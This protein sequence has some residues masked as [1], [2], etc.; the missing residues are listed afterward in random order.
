MSLAPLHEPGSRPMPTFLRKPANV[1][2]MQWTGD[3][4]A[5]EAARALHA[6]SEVVAFREDDGTVSIE[7]TGGR[8]YAQ[9]GDWIIKDN[10]G[11]LALCTSDALAANYKPV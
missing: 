10:A 4:A 6:D 9:T 3:D 5:W 1:Q 11:D 8:V 2:A 7:T